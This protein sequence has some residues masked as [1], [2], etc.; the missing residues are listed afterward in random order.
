MQ[1]CRAWKNE[2]AVVTSLVEY[3]KGFSSLPLKVLDNH[4]AVIQKFTHIQ[5]ISQSGIKFPSGEQ[6]TF[7]HP[8]VLPQTLLFKTAVVAVLI[9]Y[10]GK[11]RDSVGH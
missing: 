7:L 8:F 2:I 9:F 5:L 1:F 4:S 6:A 3:N 10:A 11:K